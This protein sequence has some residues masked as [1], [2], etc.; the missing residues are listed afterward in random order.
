MLC[1]RRCGARRLSGETGY[2][3]AGRLARVADYCAHHGEEPP[4]SGSRGSGTVFFSGCNLKCLFCQN[5]Q[6]SQPEEGL[7]LPETATSDLAGILLE[8]QDRG[9]HNINFVSPTHFAPQVAE[10]VILAAEEGLDIPVVYNSNGYDSVETLRLLEG[11][12]DIYLPDLK[13]A[14]PESSKICCGESDYFHMALPAAAEMKRQVGDLRVDGQGIAVAGLIVRHLVLP[15][16]LSDSPAVLGHILKDLGPGTAVS[17]MAQYY[18]AN[19]AVGHA[20]LGRCLYNEEYQGALGELEK[21]GLNGWTQ[22]LDSHEACR[23]DFSRP[24]TFIF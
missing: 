15:N 19:R 17:L 10:A 18:P 12:V 9:C 24:D 1:P 11:I 8:L 14:V 5:H 4:I 20:L 6:I 7:D 21:L 16:G 2:C 3:G 23:P 22:S 13:Y